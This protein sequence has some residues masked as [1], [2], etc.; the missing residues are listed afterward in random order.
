[1]LADDMLAD[2]DCLPAEAGVLFYLSHTW[3]DS[4]LKPVVDIRQEASVRNAAYRRHQER[5]QNSKYQMPSTE[6][7]RNAK[8]E[9]LKRATPVWVLGKQDFVL[10][11]DLVPGF[12]AFG[13]ARAVRASHRLRLSRLRPRVIPQRSR[14]R[15]CDWP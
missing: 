4:S 1:M 3:L 10:V 12:F 13:D 8:F 9:G 6:P 14:I 15:A 7:I 2:D 5:G 11:W